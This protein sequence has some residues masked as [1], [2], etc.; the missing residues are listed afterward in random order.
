MFAFS[1]LFVAHIVC[2]RV[3][4]VLGPCVVVWFLL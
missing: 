3:E 2:V 1:L 4:V